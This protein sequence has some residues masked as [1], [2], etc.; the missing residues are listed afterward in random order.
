LKDHKALEWAASI[1]TILTMSVV[2]QEKRGY[3]DSQAENAYQHF[4]NKNLLLRP[5]GNA[6]YLSPPYC[7]LV[8]ELQTAQEAILDYLAK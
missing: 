8:S 7:V 6:I 1:G 5:M 2:P 3:F 4:L